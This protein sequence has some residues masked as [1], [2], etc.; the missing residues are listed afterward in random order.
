MSGDHKSNVILNKRYDYKTRITN[1]IKDNILGE[2]QKNDNDIEDRDIIILKGVFQDNN[3]KNH[4]EK[5]LTL[6]KLLS[7]I[8]SNRYEWYL[9]ISELKWNSEFIGSV[10]YFNIKTLNTAMNAYVNKYQE[11]GYVVKSHENK[12]KETVVIKNVVNPGKM[13]LK[14]IKISEYDKFFEMQYTD[15]DG[16]KMKKRNK[17]GPNVSKE[18]AFFAIKEE[19]Y[20]ILEDKY[21]FSKDEP[22]FKRSFIE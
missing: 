6:I 20:K 22:I 19:K 13:I 12:K 15:K 2:L 18:D 9:S 17:F 10:S 1:D 3:Y 8:V 11:M 14:D 7:L 5:M 21:G 4:I 16:K